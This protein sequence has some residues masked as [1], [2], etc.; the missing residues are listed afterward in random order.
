MDCGNNG[1][2]SGNGNGNGNP[3][4]NGNEN[5]NGNGG[6]GSG[7]GGGAGA[8]CP[9]PAQMQGPFVETVIIVGSPS[10]EAIVPTT[11]PSTAAQPAHAVVT[12]VETVAPPPP[13]PPQPPAPAP[14]PPAP[15]PAAAAPASPLPMAPPL[16]GPPPATYLDVVGAAVNLNTPEATSFLTVTLYLP[17]APQRDGPSGYGSSPS[18]PSPSGGVGGTAPGSGTPGTNPGDGSGGSAPGSGAGASA[19]AAPGFSS[20]PRSTAAPAQV[21]GSLADR[22]GPSLSLLIISSL[23]LGLLQAAIFLP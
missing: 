14:F 15:F 4:G 5:S 11:C 6:A 20:S 21:T 19:S 18:G 7:M 2:G 10:P 8:P 16:Y 1:A 23:A 17:S 22:R 12:V 13:F 3:T 9:S